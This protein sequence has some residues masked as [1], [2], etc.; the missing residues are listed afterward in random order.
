MKL[1]DLFSLKD[2]VA[3]ITG[4]S[5][6]IGK[7]I[8]TGFAEAGANVVI[9]SRKLEKLQATAKELEVF[10][11]RIVS[12]KCDMESEADIKTLVDTTVQEFGRIDILVNNA[13]IT[14]GAPT[15]AFPQDRWDKIMSVNV[16]G[17]WILTQHVGNIMKTQ[18]R[19]KII[20]ISS[21]MGLRGAEEEDQ[22]AVAY[23]ASKAAVINLTRDLAVKWAPYGIYVNA[24][25]PG[26]FYTDMMKWLDKMPDAKKAA[27]TK[28]P[29]RRMGEED[30]IKGLAVFLASEAS[31]Y[32]TGA[33]ITVDGGYTAK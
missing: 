2:K 11:S 25:A 10:G 22:P 12:V 6:G 21:V 33:V 23:N 16:R 30:D 32:V 9:G 27:L 18:N 24:I 19:G 3:I 8:A 31:N 29:L 15:L 5:R 17:L 7:F 20:M 13:G 28:V 4:G 26:L 1:Q 14:W